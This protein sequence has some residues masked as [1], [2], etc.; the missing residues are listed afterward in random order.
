[1]FEPR[2]TLPPAHTDAALLKTAEALHNSLGVPPIVARIL[3]GRGFTSAAAARAYLE[4]GWGELHD[5]FL[6]S[7]MQAAVARI[8]QALA[9]KEK[10]LLYGDYDVDGTSSIV[11]LKTT[12][13]LLGGQTEYF[14]PHRLKDGYGM[15]ADRIEQAAREGVR[16]IISVDTGIRAAEVVALANQLGVDS[17]VTDHHLP[18]AAL[19]PA[20]AV[21]NPNQPGCIYPNKFLCGAGVAYKLAVA[22]LRDSGWS[23]TRQQRMSESLV[24]L[25]AIATVADIVPL[26]GENRALVRLGLDGLA[27]VRNAGLRSLLDVSGIPHGKTPTSRQVG[28]QIGPRINAAGRMASAGDVI[29]MFLT[30]DQA[31]AQRI[32]ETL[33]L[34]NQERQQTEKEMLEAAL[35]SAR[36]DARMGL[37]LYDPGWH[38]G[39]AGIV[40]GRIA[41]RERKPVVVLAKDEYSTEARLKGS[42]RSL[43]GF[44]LLEAL[45]LMGHLFEQF[46][47]H[48]QA[49]G[50]TLRAERLTEFQEAFAAAA[51]AG[52]TAEMR[53]PELKI[54]GIL[55]AAEVD[56]ALFETL[57]RFE[58]LGHQ[59]Q[60][61]LLAVLSAEV[62]APPKV[63]KEKHLSLRLRQ[64]GRPLNV[65]AWNM[66]EQYSWLQAGM[67]VDV[68][69]RLEP[70]SWE[71]WSAVAAGIRRSATTHTPQ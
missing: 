63:M 13:D 2:W 39:V 44:H 60:A 3:A 21:L 34:L 5:P 68:A 33:N 40:A 45:E 30:S 54:E 70:D 46:G 31:E 58:P 19:P 9:S 56:V 59:N 51:A 23:E 8:R 17:I 49:A 69:F 64:E 16:L 38:L 32:A 36:E 71:G 66:A 61:P 10:I 26:V 50:V 52:L 47:G 35:S 14:V 1:M 4:G 11:I 65:K 67:L 22:L 27:D 25:A 53:R 28:F 6:L 24:K 43:P 20:T 48:E 55:S 62:A 57:R 15:K 18:D 41:E 37:V 7:G 29:R 42:G 12:L